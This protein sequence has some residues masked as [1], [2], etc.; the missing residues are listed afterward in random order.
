MFKRK[1]NS[2]K[3]PIKSHTNLFHGVEIVPGS[4]ACSAVAA[5]A[6]QRYL[7]DEAPM[8][9]LD[10]CTD[11]SQCTCRYQHY[12]DRRTQ[13]R[14]EADEGLPPRDVPQDRRARMGRRITDT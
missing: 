3:P 2:R 1:T 6:R 7:S 12:S 9:P 4:H 11:T 8:L 13:L 10:E 5:A 14:R